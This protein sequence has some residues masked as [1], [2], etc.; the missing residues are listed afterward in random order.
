M[1]VS[2]YVCVCV[3]GDSFV[4]TVMEYIFFQFARESK[5]EFELQGVLRVK[6][7]WTAATKA[8]YVYREVL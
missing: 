2:M 4:F 7:P 3:F 1:Y 6:A 5:E 8:M